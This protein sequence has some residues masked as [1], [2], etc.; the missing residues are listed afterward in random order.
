MKRVL[1]VGA[2]M[3]GLAAGQALQAAGC[4]VQIL[5]ARP[6]IGGRTWTDCSLGLPIDLGG[7]W[8]HGRTGNPMTPLAQQADVQMAHTDFV[9]AS[10]TAVLPFGEAGRPLDIA[11]YT[12]GLHGSATQVGDAAYGHFY[13]MQVSPVYESAADLADIDAKLEEAYRELPGGDFLLYGGGYGRVAALLARDLPIA[14]AQA[15]VKISCSENDNEVRV[16]TAKGD[17]YTADYA[18]ITV[19]LGVLKSGLMRFAPALPAEKQAAIQRMGM[20]Q[21]EKIALRFPRLFWPLAPQRFNLVRHRN[22]GEPLLFGAW[23][24]WAHYAGEPVLVAYHAASGAQA[25]NQWDDERL[26]QAGMAALRLMF[27]ADVPDPVGYVR[28]RWADDPFAR[29]S[30]SFCRVGQ[31]PADRA[32]LAEPVAGRLFF[33][34]EATHPHFFSTVHGAYETGI[35]A[36]QQILKDSR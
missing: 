24:N 15:A 23:L 30:Y 13:A 32:A 10:G 21:Y 36:A 16:E 8:I 3:A 22:A 4:A 7:S 20:G 27:G 33:A 34:G 19:P 28:T 1:I 25:I 35:R 18:L 14:L 5:E 12:A 17:C 29:G 31:L 2:G 9:N 6:R 26:L 11:S